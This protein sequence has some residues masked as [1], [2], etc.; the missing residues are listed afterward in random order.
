MILLYWAFCYSTIFYLKNLTQKAYLAHNL[1][2]IDSLRT[3]FWKLQQVLEDINKSFGP[4]ILIWLTVCNIFIQMDLYDCVQRVSSYVVHGGD[5]LEG[6]SFGILAVTDIFDV[7][8][9]VYPAINLINQESIFE[10]F[11]IS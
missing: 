2:E 10:S 11:Q 5:L 4:N 8:M 6:M 3:S 9:L 1:E 7:F